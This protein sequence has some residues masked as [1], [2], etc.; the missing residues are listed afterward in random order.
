MLA[1]AGVLLATRKVDLPATVLGGG[2]LTPATAFGSVLPDRLNAAGL[3]VE[4]VSWGEGTPGEA[5]ALGG[6]GRP[7]PS[8][9]EEIPADKLAGAFLPLP[10]GSAR[11]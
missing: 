2:F 4:I 7:C 6:R 10:D 11:V 5:A 9:L 8:W 3:R 1:E